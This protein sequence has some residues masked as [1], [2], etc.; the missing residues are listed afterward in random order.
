MAFYSVRAPNG[1]TQ[2]FYPNNKQD[3]RQRTALPDSPSQIKLLSVQAVVQNAASNVT[4]YYVNPLL[5]LWTKVENF[6]AFLKRILFNGIESFF[7]IKK[8]PNLQCS[9]SW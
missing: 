4:I 6:Q 1:I 5:Q 2:D 8:S 3:T 9:M 7:E